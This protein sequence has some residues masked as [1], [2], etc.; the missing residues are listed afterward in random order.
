[1]DDDGFYRCFA[2]EAR[3]CGKGMNPYRTEK[4]KRAKRVD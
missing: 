1:M 3:V 4:L 2:I